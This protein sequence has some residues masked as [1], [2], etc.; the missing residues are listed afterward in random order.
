M[1]LTCIASLGAASELGKIHEF[2]QRKNAYKLMQPRRSS[3]AK[4]MEMRGYPLR[5]GQADRHS[6]D[7]DA[8]EYQKHSLPTEIN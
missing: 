1:I 6:H 7:D 8:L 3:Y 2:L 4:L 5:M